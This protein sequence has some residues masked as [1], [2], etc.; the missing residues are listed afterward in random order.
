MSLR[1][2]VLVIR[3]RYLGDVV[4]LG[5]WLRNVRL[6]WPEATITVLVEPAYAEALAL[7]PDVN[8]V[9]VSPAK[10]RAWPA[11]LRDVRRRAFTH[12]FNFDN[13]EGTAALT[14]W[15]G[16]PFRLG[17]YHSGF[18]LKLRGAY[19]HTVNHPTAEHESQPITEYYLCTLA[20]AGIP[21]ASRT[22]RLVPREADLA[23][24]RRFVGAAGP[25]LLVHPGSRS[26]W[27]LWPADHFAAVCDR[28]QEELG[29]QVVLVGGPGD[30]A[31]VDS[32]RTH[33]RTHLLVLAEPLP[34][35]RFAALASLATLF[36]GHDSG[37]MHIAAAVGTPVVALYGSQNAVLFRPVGEGHQLL[38]PP[39][40]C[41]A[42]VAPD[43]CV[44][45]DSYHNLCV[46]RLTL[47]E[48]FAAV[49]AQLGRAATSRV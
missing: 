35:P 1:P 10:M 39:L 49:R 22:V 20:A 17:L 27:R 15:T 23:D 32:I 2:H 47:D 25:V 33:A 8:Q 7:N 9:L 42:C 14:R 46:R 18:L 12:V 30:R 48:V 16:A 43:R 41:T 26:P 36:L 31:A 11:F 21:I 3:R 5:S 19:T 24:L 38:Q 28:A 6:H 4:L 40:P 29:A 37:P 45:E 13:T 44:P 34:L